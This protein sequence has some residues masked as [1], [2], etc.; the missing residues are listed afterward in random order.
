MIIGLLTIERLN[1]AALME[2]CGEPE[3]FIYAR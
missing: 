3:N 2:A 1:G